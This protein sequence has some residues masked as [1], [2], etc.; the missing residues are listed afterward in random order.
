MVLYQHKQELMILSQAIIVHAQLLCVIEVERPDL[1]TFNVTLLR[2]LCF[3]SALAK[4]NELE[5]MAKYSKKSS[6]S[7]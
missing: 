4:K 1:N 6:V 2:Y 5:A 3:E 7:F